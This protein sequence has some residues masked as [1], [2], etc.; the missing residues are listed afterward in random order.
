MK[1]VD[2]DLITYRRKGE[3]HAVGQHGAYEAKG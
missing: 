2:P 3:D 1:E